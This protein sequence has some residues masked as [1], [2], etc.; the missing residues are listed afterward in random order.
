MKLAEL[1]RK[2]A[3]VT[4]VIAVLAVLWWIYDLGKLHGA[5]ELASARLK[6]TM[7]NTR[8]EKLV[9]EAERLRE[10]VAVLQ[11]S[12]QIDMQAATDVRTDLEKLEDEL[13]AAREQVEFYRGIVSPGDVKAGLRIHHFGLEAGPVEGEYHYELVLTQ[14]KR[15]EKFVNGVVEWKVSGMTAEGQQ[16]LALADITEP[17]LKKQKFRFRYFQDLA[18]TVKL[19]A[20]FI[21]DRVELSIRPSGKRKQE[22]VV[23]S[24]DWPAQVP[25][26]NDAG[27]GQ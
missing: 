10:Q 27:T 11:R 12:S 26:G 16:V 15:N 13:Q 17:S 19:P 1:L 18:G 20:G 5:T 9:D 21:P 4:A 3:P 2:A 22:P 7:L 8:N 6:N 23:Q 24:Y 14:L 25:G